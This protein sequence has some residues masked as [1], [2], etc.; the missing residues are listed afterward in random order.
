MLVHVA[1]VTTLFD[2]YNRWCHHVGVLLVKLIPVDLPCACT[3]PSAE[4]AAIPTSSIR[5]LAVCKYGGGR[6]LCQV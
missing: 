1:C 5:L 6:R 3:L 2:V 4:H